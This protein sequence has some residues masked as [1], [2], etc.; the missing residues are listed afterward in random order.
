MQRLERSDGSG[1]LFFS[2]TPVYP[3]IYSNGGQ[4]IF[5]AIP[6]VRLV[7]RKLLGAMGQM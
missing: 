1:D 3:G 7:E 4:Y 5:R 6:D 2:D